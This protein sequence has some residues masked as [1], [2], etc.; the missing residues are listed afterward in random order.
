MSALILPYST[1]W[2]INQGCAMLF[3]EIFFSD[4]FYVY[5]LLNK[6]VL[7]FKHKM[8]ILIPIWVVL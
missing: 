8:M 3:I 6:K 5:G 2:L 4:F 1:L 7:R